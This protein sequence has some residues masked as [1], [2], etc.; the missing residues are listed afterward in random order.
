MYVCMISL[1]AT[2]EAQ[3]A[4]DFETR[5]KAHTD[6]YIEKNMNRYTA[7]KTTMTEGNETISEVDFKQIMIEEAKSKFIQE[8]MKEYMNLHFPPSAMITGDTLICDNGG[9]EEDFKYYFGY[10]SLF[11]E[12]MEAIIVFHLNGCGEEISFTSLSHACYKEV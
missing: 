3:T 5:M 10:T 11:F 6:N 8:N 1:P 12:G 7:E 9:F 4:S 2:V